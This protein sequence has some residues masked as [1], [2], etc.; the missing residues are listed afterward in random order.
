[1]PTRR[2]ASW[3]TVLLPLT[4]ALAAIVIFCSVLYLH[5]ARQIANA[6]LS[7]E[8]SRVDVFARLFQRD[9]SSAAGNLQL[10]GSGDALQ[11]YLVSGQETDRARAERRAAFFS[12]ENPDYDQLRY[13]DEQ[14]REIFRVDE[15]GV[16]V[17]RDQL[18]NKG[19]RPYFQ[20]AWQLPPDQIYVSAF[21]LNMEHGAVEQPFKPMLRLAMPV[22][23][24]NNQRRGVFVI[25]LRGANLLQRLRQLVPALSNRLRLLNARGYWLQGSRPDV[26]WGFM[27]PGRS[28]QTLVRTNPALWARILARPYGQA[29]DAGGYLSWYRYVPTRDEGAPPVRLVAEDDFLVF[30]S[31]ITPQEWAGAF[32]RLRQIFVIIAFLM[33]ILAMVITWFFHARRRVQIERDRFFDLTQDLLCVAGFDG[34]FKRVNPAWQKA[35]GYSRRELLARPYLDLVHPDDREKTAAQA[36]HLAEG[37][38]LTSFENRYRC[39]DGTYRWLL[40]SA[41]SLPSEQLIFGSARDLTERKHIEEKVLDLNS[42]LKHR[43][44]ELETTNRELEAFSYSVSHD[45]RAPLRHIHGFVELLQKSPALQGEEASRRQMGIIAKAAREMGLLIDDL[46]SFSRTGRAEMHPVQMDMR[47]MVD[48]VIRDREMECNGRK[49]TWQIGPLSQVAGDP[50]LMRLVWTNLLDNA[51]K[52]TRPR[53][54]SRIEVGEKIG[55]EKNHDE[56]AIVFYVR[57]NGVGFDMQYAS[58]LFGV[59]QRLHRSEDFEGTGIGLANVQRIVHR[60]GGRVWGEGRLNEGATFY[61][62]L[63]K[64][65]QPA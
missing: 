25:N 50:S 40:W 21:D 12:R 24:A 42:E 37:K 52:Y 51:L 46:L 47:E 6:T 48:Q 58:K 17:S 57:D 56:N 10:L 60:H 8:S 61:F 9:L 54:E 64:N 65:P 38:D 59:F 62:S 34:Y 7:R 11:A 23:D 2:R 16:I 1:M 30:A 13:L 55:D 14:G 43:A 3:S 32:V 41:R 22:F 20:K 18:Q 63:P 28:D 39:K 29:P 53:A 19:D 35:I 15:G 31:E 36:A 45:L 27:L 4:V 49:I 33:M 44:D 26:E 5:E